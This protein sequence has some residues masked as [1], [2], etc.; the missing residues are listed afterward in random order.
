VQ[1]LF[2]WRR[3]HDGRQEKG[4]NRRW[5]MELTR[6]VVED[7]EARE[8][9]RRVTQTNLLALSWVLGY[10]LIDP[11]V[12]HDAISFFPAKKPEMTLDEWIDDANLLYKRVGSLLL[13]RG[14]YKSTL[15]ISNCVQLLT[16]WPLTVS[17]MLMCGRS[18]L[19]VDLVIE[20]GSCFYRPHNA[21]P[22]LF[23]ALWPE[24]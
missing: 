1:A 5:R 21:P 10:T 19:A 13:P 2:D 7:Q 20:T 3:L 4:D 24:L 17:I 16:C 14:V 6:I 8:D 9:G 18:D 23:Q 22:T 15:N 11:Y 12:H